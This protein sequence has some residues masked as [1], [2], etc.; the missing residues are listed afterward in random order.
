MSSARTHIAQNFCGNER[1]DSLELEVGDVARIRKAAFASLSGTAPLPASSSQK[2][3]HRLNRGG[4]RQLNHAL[5]VIAK[6]QARIVPEV[7][8]YVGKKKMGEGKSYAEALRCL[9]RHLA[10][11]IY[12]TLVE[13]AKRVSTT[14]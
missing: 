5:H 9:Q 11:V 2:T 13:D 14:A 3:R 7:R 6:S 1:T 4:N 8:E 10:N 12:K